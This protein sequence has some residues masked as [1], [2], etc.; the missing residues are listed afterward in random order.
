MYVRVGEDSQPVYV[1]VGED[2][3]PVYVR[4]G[5][6]SQPVYVR[7]GEDSQP[8]QIGHDVDSAAPPD[9]AVQPSLVQD[10]SS[11]ATDPAF[12]KIGAFG[13]GGDRCIGYPWCG[14]RAHL[15]CGVR[16]QKLAVGNSCSE[17]IVCRD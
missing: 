8:A 11:I 10:R 12:P 17:L 9:G 7:V 6:D 16:A 4:V 15:W 2:S 1:R 3:Q 5:E 14:V 13:D